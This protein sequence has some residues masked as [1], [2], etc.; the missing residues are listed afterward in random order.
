M[1]PPPPSFLSLFD[2]RIK[3]V[4]S[5]WQE[6][7]HA[8]LLNKVI[9][10]GMS[11]GSKPV[12]GSRGLLATCEKVSFCSQTQLGNEITEAIDARL[13]LTRQKRG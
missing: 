12:R 10:S 9:G 7:A 5:D 3:D 8:P 6:T 4:N 1:C 2:L 13:K 11:T